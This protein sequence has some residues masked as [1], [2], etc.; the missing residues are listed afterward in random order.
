MGGSR[1]TNLYVHP[2]IT[3]KVRFIEPIIWRDATKTHR[4]V[5]GR[6]EKSGRKSRSIGSLRPY[7]GTLPKAQ[8]LLQSSLFAFTIHVMEFQET[9]E[10][11]LSEWLAFLCEST[12]VGQPFWVV[13]VNQ[14]H[15]PILPKNKRHIAKTLFCLV[16]LIWRKVAGGTRFKVIW[17]PKIR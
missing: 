1:S 11:F 16:W 4:V 6:H 7:Q 17:A 12:H 14:T 8:N 10:T 13:L 15:S 9:G 2:Y 3:F 5:K